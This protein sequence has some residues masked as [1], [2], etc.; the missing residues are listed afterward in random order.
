MKIRFTA[1]HCIYLSSEILKHK[2]CTYMQANAGFIFAVC[3][4]TLRRIRCS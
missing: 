4:A 2:M 1:M 3:A